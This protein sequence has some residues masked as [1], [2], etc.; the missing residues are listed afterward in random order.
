MV[1]VLE[2]VSYQGL[3][4]MSPT[5]PV[6]MRGPAMSRRPFVKR[7]SALRVFLHDP[8]TPPGAFPIQATSKDRQ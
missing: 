5:D 2:D 6:R 3:P 7:E 1:R 4:K 8:P